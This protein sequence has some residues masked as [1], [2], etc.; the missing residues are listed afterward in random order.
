M[1]Q[2]VLAL[3]VATIVGAA[4][5][6]AADVVPPHEVF[7]SVR[8]MG[9]HPL[10]QPALRGEV[11]VLRA[12]DRYGAPV[13]VV[14]EARTGQVISV[15]P[16]ARAPD[17]YYEPVPRP[18]AAIPGPRQWSYEPRA[19]PAEPR[20]APPR[21]APRFEPGDRLEDDEVGSLPPPRNPPRVATAP[22]SSETAARSSSASAA[23]MP[24]KPPLP[25]PRPAATLAA[26]G[27]PA[28]E[29][30][31]SIVQPPVKPVAPA[32]T[33]AGPDPAMPPMQGFD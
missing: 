30:T 29:V 20:Y 3:A 10:S 7:T 4:P 8:S 9:L 33:E 31:G 1:K 19:V 27:Q 21:P 18:P 14:V 5:A 17:H 22:R 24:A 11:Y 25:R 32:P 16:V 2:S 13:R 23:A 6:V 26:S 15:G 28:G 12:T